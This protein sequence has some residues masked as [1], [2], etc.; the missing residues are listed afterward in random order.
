MAVAIRLTRRGKKGSIH[1][2]IVAVEKK[3]RRDGDYIEKIG[4]YNPN[5]KE[6]NIVIDIDKLKK[7]IGNGAQLSSGLARL[8]KG[9]K[10]YG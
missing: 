9:N 7:W 4:H 5:L 3:R 6:N 1:Y 8:L 2:R 10:I